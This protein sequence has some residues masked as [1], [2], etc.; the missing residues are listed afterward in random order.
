[1]GRS[2]VI[3]ALPSVT[4]EKYLPGLS[5]ARKVLE[6]CLL[7]DKVGTYLIELLLFVQIVRSGVEDYPIVEVLLRFGVHALDQRFCVA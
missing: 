6:R 5:R 3:H 7:S 4:I 2:I 1:M